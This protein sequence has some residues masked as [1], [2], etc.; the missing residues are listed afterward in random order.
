MEKFGEEAEQYGKKRK[1]IGVNG[2]GI[3]AKDNLRT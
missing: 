3:R 1:R 2:K